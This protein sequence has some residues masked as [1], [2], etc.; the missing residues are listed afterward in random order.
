MAKVK[1]IR[2]MGL[3]WWG[4]RKCWRKFRNGQTFYLKG[5][6]SGQPTRASAEMAVADLLARCKGTAAPAALPTAP[7]VSGPN[8]QPTTSAAQLDVGAAVEAYIAYE[9]QRYQTQQISLSSWE[10]TRYLSSGF[11][12]FCYRQRYSQ[13]TSVELLA[14]RD[15][16]LGL[17]AEN[18]LTVASLRHQFRNTKALISWLAENEYLP[19][20]P[21]N[22][23]SV[24]KY[25]V[26]K[27]KVK[28]NG[29]IKIYAVDELN[30]LFNVAPD[31]TKLFMLLGLNCG[32]GAKDISDLQ[33]ADFDGQRIERGRSK[34]GVKGSWLLWGETKRLLEQEKES[35]GERLLLHVVRG[36]GGQKAPLVRQMISKRKILLLDNDRKP[37][38]Q[39]SSEEFVTTKNAVLDAFMF[40]CKKAKI[41]GN[42]YRFRATAANMVKELSDSETAQLYLAHKTA[43]GERSQSI[44]DK[45]YLRRDL[46]PLDKALESVEKKLITAG[47]LK[48]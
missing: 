26:P 23:N 38:G 20:L 5:D 40:V 22:F 15:N 3:S 1:T 27:N 42:F 37:T 2:I 8:S 21:R 4:P 13:I 6:S 7:G 39:Y 34:T 24:F 11:K 17:M 35:T 47:L 48:P 41:N 43:E 36:T 16:L 19:Q 45:H 18:R 30:A 14:Y 29:E 32:M 10:Q 28:G 44:A 31:R 12:Y 46:V 25:R 9:R 33:Q